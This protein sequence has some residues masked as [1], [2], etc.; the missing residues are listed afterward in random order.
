MTYRQIETSREIRQWLKVVIGAVG[1]V[2][3]LDYQYPDLKFRIINKFKK[4]G[5]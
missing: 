5:N 2:L 1:V 4:E 3:Y